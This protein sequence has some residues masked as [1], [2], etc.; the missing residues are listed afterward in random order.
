MQNCREL[1]GEQRRGVW[2]NCTDQVISHMDPT[3]Q[4]QKSQLGTASH[5]CTPHTTPITKE[6]THRP[7]GHGRCPA[8]A[9]VGNTSGLWKDQ[10]RPRWGRQAAPIPGLPPGPHAEAGLFQWPPPPNHLEPSRATSPRTMR[11]QARPA[12]IHQMKRSALWSQASHDS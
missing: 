7:W 10:H 3:V 12:I 9:Q 8:E 5:T 6:Q 1:P 11:I 2:G 4:A